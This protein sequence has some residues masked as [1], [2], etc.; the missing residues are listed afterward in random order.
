MLVFQKARDPHLG[1]LTWQ[2]NVQPLDL[3]PQ[4]SS[5]LLG[6]VWNSADFSND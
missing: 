6:P 3:P 5:H 4:Y 2:N 1:E